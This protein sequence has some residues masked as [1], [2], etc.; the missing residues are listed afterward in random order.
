MVLLCAG[1]AS[2]GHRAQSKD[3]LATLPADPHQ[4][5]QP[6]WIKAVPPYS[7]SLLSKAEVDLHS[8]QSNG[9][10]TIT[11]WERD[12]YQE[13]QNP[14]TDYGYK[15]AEAHYLFDCAGGTFSIL[16]VNTRRENGDLVRS[17]PLSG[18]GPQHRQNIFPHSLNSAEAKLACAQAERNWPGDARYTLQIK[19]DAPPPKSD[20]ASDMTPDNRREIER[21]VLQLK[22]R[23]AVDEVPAASVLAI[24]SGS[25][26]CRAMTLSGGRASTFELCVTQ[27]HMSHDIYTVRMAGQ[28]II[29]GIDDD[30]T[31]GIARL[32][33]GTA[34]NLKCV[35]IDQL[36][37]DVT[38]KTI[39]DAIESLK[40]SSPNASFEQ[41]KD[42]AL[43]MHSV[44]IGRHCRLT[45]SNEATATL[46]IRFPE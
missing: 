44:E 22:Q 36:A 21:S 30:T 7:L 46:D 3:V 28:K 41:R 10:G 8:V 15:V 23:Q 18:S 45:Q 26:A 4:T 40:T 29:E 35:P 13:I 11:A 34:L 12:T 2:S 20:G 1:C 27:G 32:F 19:P 39:E 16:D 25:S 37:S 38:A 24:P 5:T 14:S 9:D 43:S 17:V 31:Q 6:L 33:G 42:F